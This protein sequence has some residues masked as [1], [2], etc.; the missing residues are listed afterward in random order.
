MAYTYHDFEEQANDAARLV[1]LRSHI[2]EVNQ[3]IQADVASDGHSRSASTL[4]AY[5]LSL[6]E[7]RKELEVLAGAGN[8]S[9]RV[10]HARF[11]RD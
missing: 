1:R 4:Q 11:T 3:K 10:T 7:R 8:R 6:Q 5:L 2:T 9:A